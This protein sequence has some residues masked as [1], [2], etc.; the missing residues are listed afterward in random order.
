MDKS[1][2]HTKITNVFPWCN[3][4]PLVKSSL[5]FPFF[6]INSPR[7]VFIQIQNSIVSSKALVLL[8]FL[9]FFRDFSA[10]GRKVLLFLY[11]NLASSNGANVSKIFAKEISYFPSIGNFS[12][13]SRLIST[14]SSVP[15]TDSSVDWTSGCHA[16]GREFNSGRTNTQGL[17]KTE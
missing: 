12:R 15:R 17:K 10:G 1:C 6:P 11:R 4:S 14:D 7:G 9:K 13:I 5:P 3:C 8:G 16:E 2:W